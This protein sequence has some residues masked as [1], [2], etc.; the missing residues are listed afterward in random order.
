MV[1]SWSL[2]CTTANTPDLCPS[3][4]LS[5]CLSVKDPVRLGQL[6]G[7]IERQQLRA[8]REGGVVSKLHGFEGWKRADRWRRHTTPF[9]KDREFAP[10]H[11]FCLKGRQIA[12]KSD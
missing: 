4:P 7:I 1:E 9:N 6:V 11:S 2:L 5:E 8:V 3:A 12:V 10:I